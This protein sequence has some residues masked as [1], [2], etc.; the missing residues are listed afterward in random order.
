MLE[1][2]ESIDSDDVEAILDLL[3]QEIELDDAVAP[4]APLSDSASTYATRSVITSDNWQVVRIIAVA[5]EDSPTYELMNE[6]DSITSIDHGCGWLVVVTEE[7]AYQPLNGFVSTSAEFRY[8]NATEDVSAR[9]DISNGF[10][11]STRR[12][13]VVVNTISSGEFNFDASYAQQVGSIF[14]TVKLHRELDIR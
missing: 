11:T 13:W 10:Y 4:A 7:Q 6:Y 8:W 1:S 14:N 5:S 12:F 9:Q 3:D 2:A